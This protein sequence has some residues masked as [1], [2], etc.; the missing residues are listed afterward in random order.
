MKR[1]LL[2]FSLP[3]GLIIFVIYTLVNRFAVKIEDPVAYPMMIVSITLMLI[4]LVYNGYCFG[5]KKNPYKF[6]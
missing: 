1:K 6:N 2:A 3:T 4:G 5:K